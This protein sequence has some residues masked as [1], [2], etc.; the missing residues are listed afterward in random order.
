[1]ARLDKPGSSFGGD[2][3][4]FDDQGAQGADLVEVVVEVK[5]EG[6]VS[7]AGAGGVE[8]KIEDKVEEEV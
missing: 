3:S 2:H 6:G 5:V 7:I 4:V 1:M 8:V